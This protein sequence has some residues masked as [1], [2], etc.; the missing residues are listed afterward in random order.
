MCLMPGGNVLIPPS[1]KGRKICQYLKV[2]IALHLGLAIFLMLGGRYVDGVFDLLGA[3]I[4]FYAIRQPEGYS[5]QCVLCYCIFCGMDVFWACLRLI[6]YFSGASDTASSF[7]GW[8]YY[9]FVIGIIISPFIYVFCTVTS[10]YLYKD[11]RQA[12]DESVGGMG[13]GG[14]EMGGGGGI[15]AAPAPAERQ[16]QASWSHAESHPAA[17]S[18]FKP[19]SGTGNRLG[20]N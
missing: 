11:L 9:V 16:P 14:D 13:M 5:L 12:M 2:A 6:L 19:F 7:D 3:M 17:P 18:G 8:Q 20:G 4:G 10:Y 1:E 15:Y